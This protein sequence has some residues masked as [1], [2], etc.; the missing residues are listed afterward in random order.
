MSEA[1][2]GYPPSPCSGVCRIGDDGYCE[3]CLRTLDEIASWASLNEDERAVVY[4]RL[5][6]RGHALAAIT[7]YTD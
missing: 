1:A 5:A 2:C 4:A 3:G 6:E 7:P